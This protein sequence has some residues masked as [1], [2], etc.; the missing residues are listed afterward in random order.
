MKYVS[1]KL[2]AIYVNDLLRYTKRASTSV[3]FAI[4]KPRRLFVCITVVGNITLSLNPMFRTPGRCAW[5]ILV[6][7]GFNA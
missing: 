6:Q 7:D 4:G 3:T 2:T 1:V 5:T